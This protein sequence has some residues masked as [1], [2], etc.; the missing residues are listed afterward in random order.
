MYY[1]SHLPLYD[2]NATR[3]EQQHGA[4]PCCREVVGG[5]KERRDGEAHWG[6]EKEAALNLNT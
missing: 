1:V 4:W 5:G 2:S 6:H 3:K